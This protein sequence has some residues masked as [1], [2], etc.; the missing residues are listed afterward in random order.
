MPETGRIARKW[1]FAF[2]SPR[3]GGCEQRK[4]PNHLIEPLWLHESEMGHKG[5]RLEII[6]NS[7]YLLVDDE[8]EH[9][10]HEPKDAYAN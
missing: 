10:N 1:F 7:G 2:P 3:Y 6:T 9:S 8:K 5:R 4:N